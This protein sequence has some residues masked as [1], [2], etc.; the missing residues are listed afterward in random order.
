[1]RPAS[2][3]TLG[4]EETSM[5]CSWTADYL[6][7]EVFWKFQSAPFRPNPGRLMV[8]P[9]VV[10][11]MPLQLQG[12]LRVASDQPKKRLA[13]AVAAKLVKEALQASSRLPQA[14]GPPAW[15]SGQALRCNNSPDTPA[16]DQVMIGS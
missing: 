9:V 5:S 13:A 14:C 3:A 15:L 2:T 7:Y 8:K 10:Q 1:M 12:S 16:A 11:L 4:F 6:F